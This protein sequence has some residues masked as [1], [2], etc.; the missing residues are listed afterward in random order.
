MPD[1]HVLYYKPQCPFCRKVITFMNEAGIQLELA[2]T[3]DTTHLAKLLEV[4]GKK[5]VPCLI[6]NGSK[7]LYESDDIIAFLKTL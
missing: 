3:N 4:G 2:D 1:T 6:T 5:Q 7:A